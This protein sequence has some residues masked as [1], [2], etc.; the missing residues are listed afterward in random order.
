MFFNNFMPKENSFKKNRAIWLLITLFLTSC[1]YAPITTKIDT[2]YNARQMA[3]GMGD[4]STG[5]MSSTIHEDESPTCNQDLQQTQATTNN[6]A[7][8]TSAGVPLARLEQMSQRRISGVD[9]SPKVATSNAPAPDYITIGSTKA[10]VA[11][12]QGTP[13]RVV[14]SFNS[15]GVETWGYGGYDRIEFKNGRVNEWKNSSGFL[16]VKM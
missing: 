5:A 6:Q 14:N 13:R 11:R 7:S 2:T 16:K 10:D 15:I 4:Q 8:N 9:N 12:I 1:T 3:V